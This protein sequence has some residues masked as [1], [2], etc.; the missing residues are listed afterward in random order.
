MTALRFSANKLR[1]YALTES[2]EERN[3]LPREIDALIWGD[4]GSVD[5]LTG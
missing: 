3:S 2:L 1:D 4:T 5:Y